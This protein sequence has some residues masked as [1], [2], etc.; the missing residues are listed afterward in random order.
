MP[1]GLQFA[2]IVVCA[3]PVAALMRRTGR[4]YGFILG[5]LC[6][7]AAGL[8][9]FWA[10][11]HGSFTALALSHLLLGAFVAHAN[12]YRFAATDGVTTILRAR[13][14]ALVTAGGV[15]AGIVGPL[16]SMQTR[17]LS[18]TGEFAGSYLLFSIAGVLTLGIIA[19]LP[20][21]QGGLS[22]G[23]SGRS[24]RLV[25]NGDRLLTN[26][27]GFFCAVYAAGV[28]YMMMN[29]LMVQSTLALKGARVP[30]E[31]VGIAM[32]LHVVSMFLPSFVTGRIIDRF[33]HRFV[34]GAGFVLLAMSG[35][36]GATGV[37]PVSIVAALVLLG[38]AWNFLYVGGS[39]YVSVCHENWSRHSV[40]GLNETIVSVLAAA[41][42]F[43]AGVLFAG[44]GWSL[45]N[46]LAVPLAAAGLLLITVRRSNPAV[47][48]LTE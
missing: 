17:A 12:Y 19:A 9:G 4:R 42:A 6:A 21:G 31:F 37:D 25:H 45:S 5:A 33:G 29:M 18:S 35:L 39:A 48:E 11:D 23:S 13:A 46:L 44:F 26:P 24:E 27:W 15:L 16:L 41:G 22:E 7:V 2:A 8:V 1:Y 34:L 10:V 40:Q 43:A 38:L 20:P 30:Y 14:V 36:V 28:G 3:Y 47:P 32:Q